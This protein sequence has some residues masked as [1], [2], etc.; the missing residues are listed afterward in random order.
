MTKFNRARH[1]TYQLCPNKD[2]LSPGIST[3]IYKTLQRSTLLYGIE[4]ADWD[5]DQISKLEKIQAKA[6]RSLLDEDLQCPKVIIRILSGV[7]PFEARMDLHILL[8]YAKLSR[9]PPNSLLGKMFQYRT[10]Q[11]G[12]LPLGFF[13]TAR[14][15]LVKY[16]LD[17]LWNRIP[18]DK[19]LGCDLKAFLEKTIWL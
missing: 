7:E 10:A 11:Y 14:N 17:H 12:D 9:S 13:N 1:G 2:I 3:R 15:T 16:S 4:L 5:V 8:Y 19:D 6:L 18:E